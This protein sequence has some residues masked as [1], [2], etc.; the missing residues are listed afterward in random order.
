MKKLLRAGL[1]LAVTGAFAA[2]GI[3]PAQAVT[4][5]PTLPEGAIMYAMDCDYVFGQLWQIDPVTGDAT[6]VGTPVATANE[7]TC[8]GQ[9]TYDAVT[10]TSYIVG[11]GNADTLTV[12]D[13]TTGLHTDGPEL[14]DNSCIVTAGNDGTLYELART[15]GDY[16]ALATIDPLTGTETVIGTDLGSS[17]RPCAVANNPVDDE[18]YAFRDNGDV[19]EIGTI[20]KASGLFEYVRD[21]D[22]SAILRD[23]CVDS[24]AVD[25]NGIA[26]IQDDCAP[27]SGF[28]AVNL[29]T[30]EAWA[31]ADGNYDVGHT[32]YPVASQ[33]TNSQNPEGQFYQ[34]SI[35]I[36]PA[37]VPAVEPTAEPTNAPTTA[38]AVLA[39]TG[40]NETQIGLF[41]GFAAFA[42]IAGLGLAAARR[43]TA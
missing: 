26:W 34:M 20:D 3:V 29:A 38:P 15:G 21:A 8:A 25:A 7:I 39:S 35:W 23:V 32:I 19:L 27:D 17:V 9:G 14:V 12:V 41:A 16:L 13:V 36:V 31:M 11:W 5:A 4:P 2:A 33:I 37:A 43:R 28:T 22:L 6:P 24:M 42:V 18:I 10:G 1:V 30:G 40:T